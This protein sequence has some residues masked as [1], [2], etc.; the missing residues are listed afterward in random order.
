MADLDAQADT[1]E[2][3]ALDETLS[4]LNYRVWEIESVWGDELEKLEKSMKR[5][6]SHPDFQGFG[7]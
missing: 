7:K 1:Y 4:K 5:H 6:P 2:A 3:G